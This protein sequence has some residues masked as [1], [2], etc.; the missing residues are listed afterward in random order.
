MRSPQRLLQAKHTQLSQPFFIGEVLQPS[1]HLCGPPLDLLQMLCILLVLG[2]SC[3]S[4]VL[5]EVPHKG[6]EQG[7]ISSLSQLAT[8]P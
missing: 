2:A 5:Q 8:P 4:A 3:L 6:R 1:N 7:T